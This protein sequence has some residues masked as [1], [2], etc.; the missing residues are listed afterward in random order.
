MSLKV[1][2]ATI[3]LAPVLLAQGLYVRRTTPKLGGATGPVAGLVPGK[4]GTLRLLV[5]GESTVDGVGAASHE[6]ALTG[7]L[8]HALAR[9]TG[10][11]VAWQA[12]G[13][14]GANAR[15]VHDELLGLACPADLVV[16][17]LGVNDTIKLRSAAAFRRDLLRLIVALRRRLGP[18]PVFLAGV[19]PMGRFPALPQP[20]RAVFGLRSA[21]LDTAAASLAELPDVGYVPISA[22]LLD[23]D[24]FAADRFHPGP[25][26]Y[27]IWADQ[28]ANVL[29]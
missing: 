17:A 28:L 3:A 7:Q 9:R 2:A 24:C 11:E 29:A 19:P 15:V 25:A 13:K 1:N 14:T 20:L 5:L 10:R 23:P 4:G 16:I 27:R 8:A 21:A 18:A 26:G 12:V 6:E 22:A